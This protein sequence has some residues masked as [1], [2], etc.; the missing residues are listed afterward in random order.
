MECVAMSESLGRVGV[1]PRD[2]ETA[3]VNLGDEG[4]AAPWSYP[5][6]CLAWRL[7]WGGRQLIDRQGAVE[8]W[9]GGRV[10]TEALRRFTLARPDAAEDR[11]TSL[12]GTDLPGNG[13]DDADGSETSPE[14]VDRVGTLLA[15]SPLADMIEDPRAVIET[16]RLIRPSLS[17]ADHLAVSTWGSAT[18]RA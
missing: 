18:R 1:V 13:T 17:A 15:H 4:V 11:E 14:E 2:R 7:G 6:L 12:A 8:P 3:L 10:F 16:A 9:S 5:L